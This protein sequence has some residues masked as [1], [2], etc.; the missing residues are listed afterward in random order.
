MSLIKLPKVGMLL[1]AAAALLIFAYSWLGVVGIGFFA[2]RLN[3][4]RDM[5]FLWRP[6][7]AFPIFLIG[8]ISLKISTLL[9]WVYLLCTLAY[10]FVLSWPRFSLDLPLADW[11]LVVAV[12]LQSGAYLIGRRDHRGRF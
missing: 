9:L 11:G 7:M 8:L 1:S 3:G 4:F 10:Y 6:I 2:T 12:A 5:L